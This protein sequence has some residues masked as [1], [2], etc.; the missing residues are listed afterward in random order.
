M[1]YHNSWPSIQHVSMPHDLFRSVY[2]SASSFT[3]IKSRLADFKRGRAY[4]QDE[5]RSTPPDMATTPEMA[6]KIHKVVL[7]DR[8]E[9]DGKPTHILEMRVRKCPVIIF[10]IV[11]RSTACIT[12]TYCSI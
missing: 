5:H 8:R 9:L 1:R 6:K 11:K 2:V 10:K 12:P 3:I 4:C 7:Y